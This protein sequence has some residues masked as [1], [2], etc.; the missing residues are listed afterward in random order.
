LLS[1]FECGRHEMLFFSGVITVGRIIGSDKIWSD[2][3]KYIKV[4]NS[5]WGTGT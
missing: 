1:K 4:S 2:S 5:T 3:L